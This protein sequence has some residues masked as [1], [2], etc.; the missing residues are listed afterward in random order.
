LRT[1]LDIELAQL[2]WHFR[3]LFPELVP[4]FATEAMEAGHDGRQLRRMAGLNRPTRADLDPIIDEMFRELGRSP[5]TD[6][7]AAGMQLAEKLWG[8][9]VSGST[10][11]Y[12]GAKLIW[13]TVYY[14]LNLPRE[15]VPFVGLASEWEDHPHL[16]KRYDKD[17][18]A[19]AWEFLQRKRPP[20]LKPA[21]S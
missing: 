12:E 15:L 11:P 7:K 3:L 19:A 20:G 1:K 18:R 4:A 17:I 2:K 13:E 6:T 16:R 8:Q 14:A 9:I 10:S 5:I 21:K